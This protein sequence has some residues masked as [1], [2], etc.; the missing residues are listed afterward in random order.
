MKSKNKYGVIFDMD[1]VIFDTERLWKEAFFISNKK[2]GISLSEDFRQSICGKNEVVIR[3]ELKLEFKDLDADAYR[4]DTLLYVNSKIES[5]DFN[6]KDGFID[7]ITFL[8]NKCIPTALATSSSKSRAEKLFETK[9]LNLSE[10]FD[11]AV[12]GDEIGLLAKPNPYIFLKAS[13]KICIPAKYCIVVEDSINGIQAAVKGGF[14]SVMA[15]DLIQPD[16]FCLNNA[17]YII[18]NFSELITIIKDRI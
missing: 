11:E 9:K 14:I 10:L 1:G 16:A 15:V 6:I 13:E 5:G 18:N 2:Y 17:D 3:E 12:F 4:E 7:L 8:H